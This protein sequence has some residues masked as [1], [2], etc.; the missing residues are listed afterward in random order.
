MKNKSIIL[1]ALVILIPI[2]A[3]AQYKF[4]VGLRSGGTSGIT[5]KVNTSELTALE[6]IIGFWNDGLSITGLW[7]K[8]PSAFNVE[9]LHWYY[10]AGGHIAFY[11]AD[12]RNERGPAWWDDDRND[13]DDGDVGIGLDVI[14]GIEYKIPPIPFAISFDLKPFIELNTNG[15]T[16]FSFDPGIGLKLA[17]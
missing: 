12:Y 17:F 9:G 15:G 8:H 6:G 4:A 5:L 3:S 13:F 1:A 7:E 2:F 14:G 11:E 16:Y 10:G